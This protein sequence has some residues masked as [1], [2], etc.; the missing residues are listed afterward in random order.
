MFNLYYF[1]TTTV[2]FLFLRELYHSTMSNASFS[3]S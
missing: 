2:L 3:I 1:Y